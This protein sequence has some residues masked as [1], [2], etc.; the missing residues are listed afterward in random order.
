MADGSRVILGAL[1][2]QPVVS[3]AADPDRGLPGQVQEAAAERDRVPVADGAAEFPP[4][5]VERDD[6]GSMFNWPAWSPAA[7]QDWRGYIT[8]SSLAIL[9]ANDRLP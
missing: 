6:G 2:L 3:E 7:E 5:Q 4:E 9:R 1:D 8:V